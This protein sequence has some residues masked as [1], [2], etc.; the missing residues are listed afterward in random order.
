LSSDA[1]AG[2]FGTLTKA[3]ERKEAQMNVEQLVVFL[4]IGGIAGWLAGLITKGGGFGIVGNVV[5]GV[6]G[7]VLGGWLFGILGISI[8]G[9]WAGSLVTAIVGAVVLLFAIGL[10]RK[11]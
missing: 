4:L 7:A 3:K 9:Q 1:G 5:A 6:I 8:G 11:K 2:S 10:I